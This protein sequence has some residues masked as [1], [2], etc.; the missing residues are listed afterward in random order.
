MTPEEQIQAEIARL[1][2]RMERYWFDLAM[3]EQRGQ[4]AHALERMYDRYLKS[5]DE[6]IA[7]Q[8]AADDRRKMA[9]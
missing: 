3:A 1:E 5:L 7:C 8:R 4:P 9:S 6:F 2:K